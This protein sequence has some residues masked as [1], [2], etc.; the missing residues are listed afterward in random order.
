MWEWLRSVL[1]FQPVLASDNAIAAGPFH[2]L[3]PSAVDQ[4]SPFRSQ[5]GSSTNSGTP[6]NAAASKARP[7][8]TFGCPFSINWSVLRAIP[9]RLAR[10]A[11][12]ILRSLR[13]RRTSGPSK[14]RASRVVCEYVRRRSDTISPLTVLT[15]RRG[16][17]AWYIGH[18]ANRDDHQ[19]MT[20]TAGIDALY[21][22]YIGHSSG[23]RARQRRRLFL[24]AAH[25]AS[26][27]SVSA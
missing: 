24:G 18:L 4:V 3:A 11:S 19:V 12:V 1:C 8:S 2:P 22:C 23:R 13:A 7:I 27:A 10:S 20:A 9:I 16:V 5:I 17:R 6:S 21:G 25:A 14:P 26:E 15:G